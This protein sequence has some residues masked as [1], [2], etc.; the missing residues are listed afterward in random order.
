MPSD[1]ERLYP[2]VLVELTAAQITE[3]KQL[4]GMRTRPTHAVVC[5]PYGQI[6]GT[7]LQCRKYWEAWKVMYVGVLFDD[8]FESTTYPMPAL[9][10]TSDLTE[11]LFR[12]ADNR[13]GG[14]SYELT[15]RQAET[16]AKYQERE[17]RR[18]EKQQTKADRLQ[19]NH[20]KPS[21]TGH[22]CRDCQTA[23]SKSAKACPNCGAKKP[24][25]GKLQ[26]GFKKVGNFLIVVGLLLWL[27]PNLLAVCGGML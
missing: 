15:T 19:A 16:R 2:L 4:N 26:W 17:A 3:A 18:L 8:A 27:F 5:R 10:W 23:V 14:A 12:A 9:E 6:V 22:V 20:V 13:P 21:A 11:A 24:H 25:I 1:A 7:E